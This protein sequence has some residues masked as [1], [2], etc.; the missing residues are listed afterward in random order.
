MKSINASRLWRLGTLCSLL[1][2]SGAVAP[3]RN[4]SSVNSVGMTM[5][6]IPVGTF[7]MGQEKR[8]LDYG[9]H[10]S[11]EIDQGA[12]WD[13]LPVRQVKVT[14]PFLMSATEVTNAQYEL[15]E[16]HHRTEKLTKKIS[17][18]DDAAVV[19]VSWDDAAR[20]CAWLSQKEHKHYRLPTEAE[21]E[22]SCRAGTTT[23]YNCG[24][25]LPDGYQPMNADFIPQMNLYIPVRSKA[26]PYYVFTGKISL[27]EK[28]HAPNAW[29]LYD[30]HGNAME[31]CVDWYA[32]YDPRDTT[33]PLGKAG[34][35][36]VI[37]G[38][39]FACW[40]RLLRSANRSSMLPSMRTMQTGFRVVAGDDLGEIEKPIPFPEFPAPQPVQPHVD[41]SYDAKRPLFEGPTKYV[42]IPPQSFGPLYSSHNHDSG[43]ACL[44]SGDVLAIFYS[45]VLEGGCELA[46]A[47]ARL[48]AG[49][50]DWSPAEPF[51]DTADMNDHAPAIFVDGNTIY[52]FNLTGTWKGSYVRVSTDN[53]HTWSQFRPYNLEDPAAQ[54]NE[55]N[56]K[57]HDGRL[58]GTLDGPNETSEVM[59]S[60][61]HG[62]TWKML[63]R[64]DDKQHETPGS[65]GTAIAGIH[66]A[67]A[68]LK[69]GD[70]LAFGRVDKSKRLATY[71]YKLPRSLSKD[72]GKTWSYLI[73]EFPAVTSGQRPTM[74]RLHEGQLL[75]CSY[76]DRLLRE[77]AEEIGKVGLNTVKNLK[78][79]VRQENERD[80]M[81]LDDGHGGHFKGFGLFAA[82]SYD[83]GQTWPVK[84]L[85][86]PANV[87]LKIEATDGGSLRIDATHA[88]P[89]GYLCMAQDA[90]GRIHLHSSRNDYMFN[91]AWLT[92]GTGYARNP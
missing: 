11:V 27:L 92:E 53:G 88:E 22:Y 13:E 71:Q 84:R 48:R 38:G 91:L 73:G 60:T 66:T 81:E 31:W 70:L 63:T 39:A 62:N 19:N 12:D 55:S 15:F 85:I 17:R 14:R 82:L 80:G 21:W 36:R 68:E 35:S 8:N 4:G 2:L 72:G 23:F 32:P 56:I 67:M 83:D 46:V 9:W 29:G 7:Q 52:H 44:P 61:D 90:N 51:F 18:E 25:V 87:P 26:P 5:L 30:M 20:Y 16:P 10:C 41:P 28:Q 49:A 37:R 69:N 65:A 47:S 79:L 57:T 3:V 78:S 74:K 24:D 1:T 58:L 33:D 43:I 64:L 45:T 59:E 86:V 40:G 76:T 34:N 54:P 42:K 6:P 50:T 75:F 89:N 77:R